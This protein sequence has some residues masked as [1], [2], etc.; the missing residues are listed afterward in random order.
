ME[1]HEPDLREEISDRA[2]VL[3]IQEDYRNAKL[4]GATRRLLDFAVKLTL[5]PREMAEVDVEQLRPCGFSDEQILDAVQLTAYFN[6]VNR[7]LDGLGV[8]PEPGMRFP[9]RS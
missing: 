9:R 8:E 5:N 3:L 2:E 1:S 7:V 6:Y 4:D